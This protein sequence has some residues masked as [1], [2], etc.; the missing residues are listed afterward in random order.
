MSKAAEKRLRIAVANAESAVQQRLSYQLGDELL[1]A[2]RNPI[3]LLFLPYL[4][5]KKWRSFKR[6][7]GRKKAFLQE[8]QV[9][10]V[11]LNDSMAKGLLTPE[12][13]KKLSMEILEQ[14][15]DDTLQR[16]QRDA[17]LEGEFA[18]MK[19]AAE[20]LW[21]KNRR[22][23]FSDNLRAR[24]GTFNDLD[25]TWLPTIARRPLPNAVP[26]RILHIF[27]TVYP[28]ESSGGA[29]RN[30]SIARS[31]KNLGLEP[32]IIVP[33]SIIPDQI[34]GD[35]AG[36]DGIVKIER[37]GI[38]IHG[39]HFANWDSNK[40]PAD[41]RLCFETSIA[42]RVCD[43]V[44]PSIIHAASGFRGYDNALKGL[45]L[46]RSRHLPFVYEARSFHEHTWAPLYDGIADAPLT[47]MRMAQEDRCMAE[48]DVVVTISDAMAREFRER[49][50][51]DDKL[52][53]VPNSV[54]DHFL[55]S[56]GGEEGRKFRT[57][58]RLE[59]KT[60]IGYVS[61]MSNREGHSVL[62][63]AFARMASDKGEYSLL[64]VGDGR[65]RPDLEKQAD[66]LGVRSSIVFTG[67]I[68]HDKIRGAYEAIDVFV[69]PRL[70]DY[71][72]D[73]V[74]PMKPFEAMA[75]SRPVIMSDRPVSREILGDEER[76]L[77]FTTG[78]PEHLAAVIEELI[79][80]DE[81]T[82]RRAETARKWVR[83]NRTWR[84]NALLYNNI[85][86]TAR[87]RFGQGTGAL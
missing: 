68:D 40:L 8:S 71:A 69:V 59:G 35:R 70:S 3:R 16:L 87:A 51:D 44:R 73:Y 29:V 75:L 14:A 82:K 74:T 52:F 37:D 20:T 58:H 10:E 31:Q 42:A 66:R 45:A 78:D 83:D 72:S 21:R 76:G 30:W 36:H 62:I 33:P 41:V 63:D 27:K 64:L 53:I 67:T 1:R 4:I 85:Y 49:G 5:V 34:L 23:K 38:D 77:Y 54:D 56:G 46:A 79:L 15:S 86:E 17:H 24:L 2:L 57:D 26:D 47:K 80:D 22:V 84:A 43:T 48:A 18:L 61:N 25:T 60:V 12:T 6:G 81:G 13:A 55:A 28:L 19:L 7:K 39:C 9:Y 65:T 50:V 11:E 32:S